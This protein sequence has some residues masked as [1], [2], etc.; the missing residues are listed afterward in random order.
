ML[1]KLS[2]NHNRRRPTWK[3]AA[4]AV[5]VLAAVAFAFAALTGLA[6]SAGGSRPIDSLSTEP[7]PEPPNLGDFAGTYCQLR[8]ARLVGRVR[9]LR[10]QPLGGLGVEVDRRDRQPAAAEADGAR[11]G[12][13]E[14]DPRLLQVDEVDQRLGHRAE[15][16]LEL[17][18]QRDQL[19]DL[20]RGGDPAVDVDLRLLVGDVVGRHVG[21]DV[22]VEPHRL[23]APRRRSPR[24]ARA[25]ASS[26]IDR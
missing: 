22:D 3:G 18:A 9:D 17:V 11:A 4:L 8:P 23:G 14:L 16:V 15:A 1:D 7:V 13:A 20:A 26:S 21:V 24:L 6:W 25:T 10:P 2:R 12:L 5:A 19:G